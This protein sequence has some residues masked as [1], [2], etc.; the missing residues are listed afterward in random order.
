MFVAFENVRDQLCGRVRSLKSS[1]PKSQIDD[2]S[3]YF[4]SKKGFILDGWISQQFNFFKLL[5]LF[6]LDNAFF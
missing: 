3:D 5:K 4:S 2:I 1:L 6:H